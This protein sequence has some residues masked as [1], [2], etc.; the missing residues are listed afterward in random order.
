[1]QNNDFIEVVGVVFWISPWVGHL[2]PLLALT[3]RP[4]F[5]SPALGI[6]QFF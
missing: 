4:T 2:P 3:P 5:L 6:S 1:M